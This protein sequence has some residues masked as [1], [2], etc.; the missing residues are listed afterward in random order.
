[1][2]VSGVRVVAHIMSVLYMYDLMI[3]VLKNRF[4]K[5]INYFS[6]L[7]SV[8]QCKQCQCDP[9]VGEEV[10]R[11]YQYNDSLRCESADV[12]NGL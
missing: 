11:R 12:R 8:W 4:F 9:A 6:F 3:I 7:V 2:S 10:D 1:M 5:C